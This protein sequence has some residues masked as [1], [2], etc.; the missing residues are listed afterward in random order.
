MTRTYGSSLSA[1]SLQY[2]RVVYPCSYKDTLK[3]VTQTLMLCL[4]KGEGAYSPLF[5]LS[6]FLPECDVELSR[7]DVMLRLK[8]NKHVTTQRYP[9]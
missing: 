7:K 5:I 3:N 1:M 8:R 6:G 4:K 9:E 2:I